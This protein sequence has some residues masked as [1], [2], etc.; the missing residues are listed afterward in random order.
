MTT[1]YTRAYNALHL[2]MFAFLGWGVLTAVGAFGLSKTEDLRLDRPAA[3]YAG[4]LFGLPVLVLL[5]Q[6]AFGLAVPYFG[7]VVIAI[8]YL[9]VAGCTC[10]LGGFAAAW[11]RGLPLTSSLGFNLINAAL[12]A[13]VGVAV[14]SSLAGIAQYLQV[15]L[16][17]FLVSPLN[18]I[19]ASYG[20]LRQQ[21]LFALLGVLGLIALIVLRSTAG[22]PQ[23][24]SDGLAVLVFLTLL[25]A[26]VL[27][28]SRTG[29]LL[30][31]IISIW[32]LVESWRARQLMWMLLLALPT[33]LLFRY[34]AVQIDLQGLLPFHGTNRPG[35]ISTALEGDYWRQIIW[36]KSLALVRSH[37]IWGVGFGNIAYAMFTETLPV[38]SASVTEHAHNI[39]L[40]MAVELGAPIAAA[41]AFVL[42]I[43]IVRSRHALR[44]FEGRSL[45]VFLLA[46]MIH[47]L[48][49]YPL[50][51]AYFLLPGAFA[52]G[53]FTQIGA[54]FR[55]EIRAPAMSPMNGSLGV[56]SAS[57][58]PNKAASYAR[59]VGIGGVS[60]IILALFGLW[61][62]AKVSP[63]Y[64]LNSSVPLPDRVIQSYESVLFLNLADYSALN[65]TGVSPA[66][67][68]V[69]LRLANRV[70]HF[71]FDP[72]VAATH[73]AAASLTGQM[74]LAK[75]SAYRLW[76]K[77]K[78]AAERLR[79]ALAGS[80]L[81]QALELSAFLSKPT[82]VPW[83]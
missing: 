58:V 71:R 21:N 43:L 18:Q 6:Q 17:E 65:L 44:S 74:A 49:E 10:L 83:P 37:P 13:F 46:V 11:F 80:G 61:D 77:D 68:A 66:T 38:P 76:L 7:M 39:F 64:E 42:A 81:P 78:D 4:L 53:V 28:T 14:A 16:P 12:K 2:E 41:W 40:Q 35:L 51:Y 15:P 57:A 56:D 62:Y 30:V 1:C 55:T 50:W 27:S 52:L 79:L 19:G 9:L 67:A 31:G 25:I 5:G 29:A 32:G 72:Q 26:I 59:A 20:N 75:A 73:A 54:L 60:T 48:L 70:A 8:Y 33:Y 69:Q 3:A 45:A 36:T 82:F 23:W 34:I 63:S 47:S 24:R 22:R